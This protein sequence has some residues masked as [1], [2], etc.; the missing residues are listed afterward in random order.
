MKKTFIKIASIAIMALGL[1]GCAS[2]SLPIDSTSKV[3]LVKNSKVKVYYE[4]LNPKLL[5]ESLTNLANDLNNAEIVP[6]FIYTIS[7][8]KEAPQNYKFKKVANTEGKKLVGM[9]FRLSPDKNK[10]IYD[11][12]YKNLFEVYEDIESLYSYLVQ[13]LENKENRDRYRTSKVSF[14]PSSIDLKGAALTT[15][16][17]SIYFP[18][19]SHIKKQI[20]SGGWQMVEKKEDADKEISFEMS[21]DYF[22]KE[23]KQLKEDNKGIQLTILEDARFNI[24]SNGTNNSNHIVVGQSAMNSV[25]SSNNDLTSALVGLTVSSVFS[26]FGDSPKD[27]EKS[28]S[29]VALKVTDKKTSTTDIKIFDSTFKSSKNGESFDKLKKDIDK[30]INIGK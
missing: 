15:E 29:F 6:P 23:L 3:D 11:K 1:T 19:Y 21:R 17:S 9:K 28:V 27:I 14:D 2:K 13:L 12:D 26:M 24:S 5:I 10:L 20:V 16:Y 7:N 8:P 22:S 25:S 18:L 30:E 4:D